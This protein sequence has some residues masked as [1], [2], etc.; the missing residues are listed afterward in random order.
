M[1][2]FSSLL[3]ERGDMRD[4]GLGATDAPL[5]IPSNDTEE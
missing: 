4:L 5:H 3:S 2:S 1:K